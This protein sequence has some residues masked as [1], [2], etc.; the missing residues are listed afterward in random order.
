MENNQWRHT[1]NILSLQA[2]E[3]SIHFSGRE[4]E[5]LIDEFIVTSLDI[6]DYD[7]N[8]CSGNKNFAECK[9][10]GTDWKHYCKDIFSVTGQTAEDYYNTVLYPAP[11]EETAAE[12]VAVASAETVTA[13]KTM[14]LSCFAVIAAVLSAAGFAF[15]NKK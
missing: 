14:D 4:A 11:V 8:A 10:C 9:F 2:G 6:E 3:H 7:P 5:W 15:T 13:P 12:V 1:P